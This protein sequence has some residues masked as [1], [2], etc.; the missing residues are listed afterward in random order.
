MLPESK[1]DLKR[2][3]QFLP[4]KSLSSSVRA[5]IPGDRSPQG[6]WTCPMCRIFRTVSESGQILWLVP[7]TTSSFSGI[8]SD[9]ELETRSPQTF[10]LSLPSAF[11]GLTASVVAPDQHCACSRFSAKVYGIAQKADPRQAWLWP[12]AKFRALASNKYTYHCDLFIAQNTWFWWN[13]S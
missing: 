1:A 7:P 13:P 11:A 3:Q 9:S 6:T 12:S 2:Q 10:L 5:G 4:A 8:R